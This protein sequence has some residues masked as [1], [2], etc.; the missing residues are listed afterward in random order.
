MV[1][2]IN[3]ICIYISPENNLI[4]NHYC[5]PPPP[6]GHAVAAAAYIPEVKLADVTVNIHAELSVNLAWNSARLPVCI[7]MVWR[8]AGSIPPCQSG[9]RVTLLGDVVRSFRLECYVTGL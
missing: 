1:E 6:P 2:K 8:E 3:I 5:R 4:P 9:Q 7:S